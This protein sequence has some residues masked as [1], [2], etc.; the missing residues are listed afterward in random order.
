CKKAGVEQ[1]FG[2]SQSPGND[3]DRQLGHGGIVLAAEVACSAF[4]S[5]R[6]NRPAPGIAS[7]IAESPRRTA[8]RILLMIVAAI[9][10]GSVAQARTPT[11][12]DPIGFG[13]TGSAVRS[14]R[15]SVELVA[16]HDHGH[17]DQLGHGANRGWGPRPGW[18]SKWRYERSYHPHW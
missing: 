9:A 14:D 13:R 3:T 8:M 7:L 4:A 15:G 16:D 12:D 17:H 10:F 2:R 1:P 5:R 11:F 6:Q 18:N